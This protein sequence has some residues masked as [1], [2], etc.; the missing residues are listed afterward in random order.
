MYVTMTREE[1]RELL[2]VSESNLQWI[3]KQNK[4]DNR[5]S[6]VGYKFIK[7]LKIGRNKVY[8]L[9]IV[10]QKDVDYL[11][12]KYNIRNKH[13]DAHIEYSCVRLDGGLKKSKS[14]LIRNCHTKVTQYQA[15]KYD[16]ILESEGIMKKDKKYYVM[17]NACTKNMEFITKEQYSDFWSRNQYAKHLIYDNHRQLQKRLISQKQYDQ[18]RDII[19]DEIKQGEKVVCYEFDTYQEATDSIKWCQKFK[20][21]LLELKK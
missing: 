11:Q 20:Q 6:Q 8:E 12:R 5:L 2:Q 21:K 1:L 19:I 16:D 15:K 7:E 4:L 10:T 14:E 9:D 13:K 18:R 3:L 17:Y